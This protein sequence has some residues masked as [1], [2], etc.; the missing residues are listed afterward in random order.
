[1]ELFSI[2]VD[3]NSDPKVEE[4][5]GASTSSAVL[6]IVARRRSGSVKGLDRSTTALSC[7]LCCEGEKVAEGRSNEDTGVGVDR[8]RRLSKSD[9]GVVGSSS[10]E[11]FSGM[12]DWTLRVD[13]AAFLVR[14]S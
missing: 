5:P 14:E 3:E 4:A 6:W 9:P 10:C 7:G 2:A 1:M 12:P 8:E 11:A 13:F